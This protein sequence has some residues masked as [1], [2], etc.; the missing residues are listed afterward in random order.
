LD[1]GG[2]FPFFGTR[3]TRCPGYVIASPDHPRTW[4]VGANDKLSQRLQWDEKTHIL[5]LD[6]VYAYVQNSDRWNP[7]EQES[8]KI[9]F[10]NV[11]WDQKTDDLY[12]PGKSKGKIVIGRLR[13]AFQG[14][15]VESGQNVEVVAHRQ[16][17]H[18]DAALI[19]H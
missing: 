8:F 10:P 4:E 11:I 5:F 1:R 13:E 12:V 15:R 14:H 18:I 17:K 7:T 16:D 19:V 3:F 2:F 9:H 6:V